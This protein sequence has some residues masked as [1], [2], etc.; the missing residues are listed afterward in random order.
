MWKKSTIKFQSYIQTLSCITRR[1]LNA[2]TIS[3]PSITASYCGYSSVD[4]NQNFQL[5]Q[6]NIMRISIYRFLGKYKELWLNVKLIYSLVMNKRE[7]Q[8]ISDEIVGV[9][10][11]KR[12]Q[13]GI[14]QYKLAQETGLSKSSILYI[15]RLKQKPAMYTLLMIADCL[16]V[17]LSDV[18][19]S[20][21]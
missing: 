17:D 11:K 18:L 21:R 3:S 19:K 1:V 9:L 2:R 12:I 10:R 8:T 20:L 7:A 5:W 14:S 13:Q 15:E 16:N 4:N 6:V